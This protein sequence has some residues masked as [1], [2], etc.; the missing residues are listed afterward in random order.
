MRKYKLLYVIGDSI[1]MGYC[2]LLVMSGS[3]CGTLYSVLHAPGN[4]GNSTHITESLDDWL[5]GYNPDMVLFNCG[6]HDVLR[7]IQSECHTSMEQYKANLRSIVARLGQFVNPPRLIWARTT[8]VIDERTYA[9]GW[10]RRHNE[11]IIA[12]NEVADAVMAETGVESIDL[13][14][15]VMENDP[16]AL[17]TS[18]GSH[19]TEEG[20][21]L[22]D[23][24][25]AYYLRGWPMS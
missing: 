8:P 12:Y 15:V 6:L 2:P 17:I 13:Y 9:S 10:Q 14:G 21:K 25:I 3:A 7:D 22:L 5:V 18:D 19:F 1:S 11:D 20:Y 24:T 23:K 16:S 4:S